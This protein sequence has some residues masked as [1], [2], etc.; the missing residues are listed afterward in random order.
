MPHDAFFEGCLLPLIALKQFKFRGA[1]FVSHEKDATTALRHSVIRC[2]Y[3][4]PLDGVS[5]VAQTRQHDGKISSTLRRRTLQK[6]IDVFEKKVPRRT[7]TLL[8]KNAFDLPPQH[9]LLPRR[10]FEFFKV[11]ATE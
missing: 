6:T 3:D 10:P 4:T 11:V 9:P 1:F 7:V 5:E 8:S 2:V